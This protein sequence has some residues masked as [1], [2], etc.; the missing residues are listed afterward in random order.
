M[1]EE[2]VSDKFKEVM[3]FA[4]QNGVSGYRAPP[5]R[6]ATDTSAMP[7]AH[8]APGLDQR[9]RSSGPA[10]VARSESETAALTFRAP[11]WSWWRGFSTPEPKKQQRKI[12]RA[13]SEHAISELRKNIQRSPRWQ[14]AGAKPSEAARARRGAVMSFFRRLRLGARRGGAP[15]GFRAEY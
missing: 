1:A 14:K 3:S 11:R 15:S 2:S 5:R 13:V 6:A 7:G 8:S 4:Q 9:R 10:S 12:T